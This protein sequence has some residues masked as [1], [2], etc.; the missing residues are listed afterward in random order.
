ML[1]FFVIIIT[2]ILLIIFGIWA[3]GA[4]DCWRKLSDSKF[5]YRYHLLKGCQYESEK[6][7][8]LRYDRLRDVAE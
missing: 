5:D 6:S 7:G 2:V 3:N 4:F 1:K 8:W